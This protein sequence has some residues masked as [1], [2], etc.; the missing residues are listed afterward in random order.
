MFSKFNN[1]GFASIVEVIVT[2]IIFIITA[3]GMMATISTVKTPSTGSTKKLE[4]TYRAKGFA[5]QLRQY[6]DGSTWDTGYGYGYSSLLSIGSY[7]T[8]TFGDCTIDYEIFDSDVTGLE[9]RRLVMNI[10]WP[11]L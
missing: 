9:M 7:G 11:D 4:C 1:Q 6:V 10:E 2:S 8:T 3:V 5:Q